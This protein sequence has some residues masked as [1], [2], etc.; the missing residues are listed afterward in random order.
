[1][2][3]IPEIP[4]IDN[5]DVDDTITF[6]CYDPG[7]VGDK[8]F[9]ITRLQLLLGVIRDG[10]DAILAS[11]EADDITTP[12]AAITALTV[13]STLT[14]TSGA[15]IQKILRA[16]S[17]LSSL[18]TVSGG[19]ET[20]TM[21]VTGAVVHDHVTISFSAALPTGLWV[22]AWVSATNTVS[23]KFN[24][25]SGGSIGAASYAAQVVVMRFA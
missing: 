15:T 20:I 10:A 3:T 19:T 14:F 8:N 22:E 9:E 2:V 12:V 25:R 13:Q 6:P 11:L 5:G 18:G 21:T 23:V 4:N 7:A 24:N 1:M 17:S 16:A